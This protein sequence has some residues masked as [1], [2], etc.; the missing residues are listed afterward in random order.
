MPSGIEWTDAAREQAFGQWLA[1]T[2]DAH[3][4]LPHTVRLASADASFRRYFRVDRASGGSCIVMDAPPAQEN[5]QPFVQ[6]AELM[7]EAGLR[8]PDVLAW[9]APQGFMLLSDLGNRT[10]LDVLD[11]DRPQDNLPHFKD[12]TTALTAWQT[13]SRPGVLPAWAST[14]NLP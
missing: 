11:F 5:C 14:N 12:A 13:A 6:V 2:S 10:L 9:D 8:V 4:L 1:A 7:K 3:G